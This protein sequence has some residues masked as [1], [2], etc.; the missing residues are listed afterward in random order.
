M[1]ARRVEI[2][3]ATTRDVDHGGHFK[4]DHNFVDRKPGRVSER[5]A[6]P[7]TPTRIWTEVQSDEPEFLHASSQLANRVR[8]G[9]AGGLGELT[10]ANECRGEQINDASDQIVTRA[11]PGEAHGLVANVMLHR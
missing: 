5:K 3:V 10:R 7:V 1:R 8:H 4:F 9:H 6:V 2:D 11:R